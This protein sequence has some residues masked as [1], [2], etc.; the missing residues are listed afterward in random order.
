MEKTA[1]HSRI[2]TKKA[3]TKPFQPFVFL[4]QIFHPYRVEAEQSSDGL[5][6]YRTLALL[7]ETHIH[8]IHAASSSGKLLLASYLHSTADSGLRFQWS[9]KFQ[10][11]LLLEIKRWSSVGSDAFSVKFPKDSNQ[12]EA[13]AFKANQFS[14]IFEGSAKIAENL[15]IFIRGPLLVAWLNNFNTIEADVVRF[16]GNLSGIDL[17]FEITKLRNMLLGTYL[18]VPELLWTTLQHS[19]FYQQY[20]FNPNFWLVGQLWFLSIQYIVTITAKLANCIID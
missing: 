17:V 14:M 12:T 1:E 5:V 11:G 3:L 15:A 9:C 4:L 10:F 7:G 2:V 19:F 13:L 20:T 16:F 8:F 6:K 18:F